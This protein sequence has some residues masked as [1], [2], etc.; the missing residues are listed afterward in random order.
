ME[1]E[2]EIRED[3]KFKGKEDLQKM[4]DEYNRKM[5]ELENKKEGELL[6]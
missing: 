1:K 3:D 2:G 6:N 5:E 4:V